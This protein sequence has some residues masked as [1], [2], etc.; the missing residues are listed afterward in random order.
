[1]SWKL[2]ESYFP[3]DAVNFKTGIRESIS[4]FF[5]IV[6]GSQVLGSSKSVDASKETARQYRDV[7]GIPDVRIKRIKV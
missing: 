2:W 1:M 4:E 5:I 7:M 3:A 6:A